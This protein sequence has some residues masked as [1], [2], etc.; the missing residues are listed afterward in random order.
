MLELNCPACQEYGIPISHGAH[1]TWIWPL[2]WETRWKRLRARL[3]LR[4]PKEA[5]VI[6]NEYVCTRCGYLWRVPVNRVCRDLI[7]GDS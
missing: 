6:C 5:R 2:K 7:F 4:R 1:M 3:F